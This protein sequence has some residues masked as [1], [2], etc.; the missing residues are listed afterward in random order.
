MAARIF[1]IAGVNGAGKSSIGGAALTARNLPFY[2]PDL[3]ARGLLEENP[4]MS[5]E[6]A[7][8]HAWEA[9]RKGLE[10]AL[11]GGLN[12]AFETTLGASTIPDMLMAGARDGAQLSMWYAGLSSPELHL[13]RVRSR[14]ASGGHDI[15]A[16]KIRERYVGSRANL[17]RLLPHLASLRLYDN[18]AENDPKAGNP[19][20]PVLLLHLEA[21]RI[22]SHIALGEVP[23]WAKP[24]LA[25][26]LEPAAPRLRSES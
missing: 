8:A 17:V 2:N 21:G 26:A 14:V 1:V 15:P 16:R 24:I 3:T 5:I 11:E 6:A 4:G 12:F 22:V 25:S 13:Q 7:N 9:G 10:R 23:H 18:S 19:P 20:R